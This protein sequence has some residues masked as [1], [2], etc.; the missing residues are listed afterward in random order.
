MNC[1]FLYLVWGHDTLLCPVEVEQ[2]TDSSTLNP[3]TELKVRVRG[4][5]K[6]RYRPIVG[7]LSTSLL[8]PPPPLRCWAF[9]VK[10]PT[11]W[12][13]RYNAICCDTAKT[14][15]QTCQGSMTMPMTI[16]DSQL[17]MVNVN[18]RRRLQW[19]M[20]GR[21]TK[22]KKQEKIAGGR[23]TARLS[24]FTHNIAGRW[25]AILNDIDKADNVNDDFRLVA[26]SCLN[27]IIPGCKGWKVK[28]ER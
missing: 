16:G 4:K 7:A 13:C 20:T 22:K 27:W 1:T 23:S 11:R 26:R 21:E 10:W 19:L 24:L 17:I 25:L 12:Q 28:R 18:C 15:G 14:M 6:K 9:L 5:S 3:C 8:L 2:L